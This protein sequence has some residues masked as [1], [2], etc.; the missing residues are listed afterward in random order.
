MTETVFEES[1]FS[2]EEAKDV[3]ACAGCLAQSRASGLASA[4]S[5]AFHNPDCRECFAIAKAAIRKR[6][7]G[8]LKLLSILD[9]MAPKIE[10]AVKSFHAGR[11]S[12]MEDGL[13][14]AMA[15]VCHELVMDI[16]SVRPDIRKNMRAMIENWLE[17]TFK[18]GQGGS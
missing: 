3:A 13:R 2:F 6:W 9:S 14:T 11:P 15:D 12:A 16:L 1:D 8:N 18:G 4:S 5:L 10:Q 7:D 17:G